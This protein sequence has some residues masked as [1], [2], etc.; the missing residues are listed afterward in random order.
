MTIVLGILIGLNL[1][2]LAANV[3][4][5]RWQRRSHRLVIRRVVD[6]LAPLT[7]FVWAIAESDVMPAALRQLARD[8]LARTSLPLPRPRPQPEPVDERASTRVH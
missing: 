6:D 2:G 7:G 3:A 5:L 4:L 8:T 1:A